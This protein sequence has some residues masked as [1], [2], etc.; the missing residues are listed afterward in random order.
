MKESR[1][2]VYFTNQL[3]TNVPA[4]KYRQSILVLLARVKLSD[5]LS[6][7]GDFTL[8]TDERHSRP[9]SGTGAEGQLSLR[10]PS[11]LPEQPACRHRSQKQTRETF[12]QLQ[13]RSR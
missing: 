4:N 12:I 1:A 8:Q 11:T 6:L 2:I 10:T 13:V 9:A 7:L 5:S 3:L